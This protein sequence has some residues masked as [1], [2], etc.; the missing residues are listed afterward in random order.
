ME[1]FKSSY[2]RLLVDNHITE[3]DPSFMTRFDP[4]QFVATVASSGFDSCMVYA[5]CHN[6]NCY[7]PTRVGHMHDNLAGRDIFGETIGLLRERGIK[8]VAY[9]TVIWHNHSAKDHPLWRFTDFTGRQNS[10]RYWL[11]CPNH[12]DYRAFCRAQIQ[13]ITAYDFDGLFI[14]MTFWPGVCYCPHCRDRYRREGGGELPTTLDWSDPHWVSFHRAR[15]RWL[16]EFADVLT[17]VAKA[18]KPGLTVVHQFSPILLGW[19]LAQDAKFSKASDYASGDFYGGRHQQRLGTKVFDALTTSRP[20]EFM[21]SRCEN[22]QNHTSMK[23]AAEL[24][25]SAATTLANGGAYFFIDA[26]N[27]DGTLSPKTYERFAEV[28]ETLAPVVDHLRAARPQLIGDVGLYSSLSS[29]VDERMNGT[30]M[31]DLLKTTSISNMESVCQIR[32]MQELLGASA[33]LNRMHQPYVIA[34]ARDEDLARF[35]TII[36]C[37]ATF[38]SAAEVERLRQ[39]VA[40]GGTLVATGPTSLHDSDGATTGDFA[41]ADVFGVHYSGRQSARI[42]YLK[43][44]DGN[45]VLCDYPAP[46]VTATTAEVR[47]WVAE[48]WFDPDD[49]KYA[50]IHSNP[51]GPRTDFAAY[52]VNR[53]GQGICVYLNASWLAMRQDAQQ[54]F[55]AGVLAEHLQ[56]GLHIATDAPEA[57]EITLLRSEVA[58]SLL[59]FFVNYQDTM[60]NIPLAGLHA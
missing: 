27:P 20:Y 56:S 54:V 26:I 11:S 28:N 43:D 21:T 41:L 60:P 5:C 15:E 25:A 33:V 32:T 30:S 46:L 59:V 17:G 2:A 57:V 23:S 29:H 9:Y 7:Y 36:L 6:G 8:P 39:F 58:N 53:F 47:A 49:E 44:A 14:D 18:E 37:G 31:E 4:E 22:L 38:L 52:A 51:P 3:D 16:N 35:R 1:W 12:P 19:Y 55:C 42:N 45:H 13:E 10:G 40:D 48:P 34:T 50:S 24:L